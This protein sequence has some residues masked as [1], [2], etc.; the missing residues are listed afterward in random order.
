VFKGLKIISINFLILISVLISIEFFT[1]I[2]VL[3]YRCSLKR[4][5]LP[6][7][8]L[9]FVKEDLQI[10]ISS[11]DNKL[12]YV[13]KDGFDDNI[14]YFGWNK[15]RVT[16]EKYGIRKSSTQGLRN[17]K[18][19]VLTVG[20]S[21]AFG[22]QVNNNETWQSCLNLK[23]KKYNF[24]NAGVFG[25]GTG[26][27]YLRAQ[28]LSKKISPRPD[29]I[30]LNHLVGHDFPRD[31]Y[32]FRTGFPTPSLVSNGDEIYISS[33]P[34]DYVIGTKFFIP[35]SN[36]EIIQN[37]ILK[38]LGNSR[39]IA[40]FNNYYQSVARKRVSIQH[41][42]AAS[43]DEIREWIVLNSKESP[44]KI[45]WLLQYAETFYKNPEFIS[46]KREELIRS[47]KFNDLEFIDT[48]II[49]KNKLKK[50]S[51]K[52]SIWNGHHTKYGNELVCKSIYEFLI[53]K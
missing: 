50:G 8:T 32:K 42:S 39:I 29:F 49:L 19:N 17:Q 34:T 24:I 36:L 51:D 7:N 12:G 10:G 31:K 48:Y 9:G 52:N 22:D 28:I 11:P 25:Y 40:K 14:N 16:I 23:Q 21:F 3:I 47:L 46:K 33:P 15:S 18:F 6:Q 35:K 13:P 26:Q 4:V 20:D 1:R 2:V 38:A 37:N 27:A 43:E 5:C 30:I 41:P 53:N 44:I 45:I